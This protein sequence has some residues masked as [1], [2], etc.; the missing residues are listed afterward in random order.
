MRKIDNPSEMSFV[1]IG[2]SNPNDYILVKI[3]EIDHDKGRERGIPLFASDDRYELSKKSNT[4]D[5]T[6][7][8]IIPGDNLIPVLGGLL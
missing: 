1:E 7:I 4:L 5:F 2:E 3:T 6:N 8:I